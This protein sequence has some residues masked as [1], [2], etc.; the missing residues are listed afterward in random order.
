MPILSRLHQP[1]GPVTMVLWQQKESA[2][3]HASVDSQRYTLH[4]VAAQSNAS[5]SDQN[6][7]ILSTGFCF[8]MISKAPFKQA[9]GDIVVLPS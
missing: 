7:P 1:F 6:Y 2:S 8:E 9:A 5:L 4:H 3:R